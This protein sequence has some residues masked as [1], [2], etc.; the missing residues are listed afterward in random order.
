VSDTA[1]DAIRAYGLEIDIA[2]LGLYGVANRAVFVIDDDGGSS[3]TGSPTTRRTSRT[4]TPSS[5]RSRARRAYSV[6]ILYK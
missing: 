1:G 2:D 5:T 6:D 4:T 3:T